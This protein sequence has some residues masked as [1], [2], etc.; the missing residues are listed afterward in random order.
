ML[1]CMHS[2]AV[3][4]IGMQDASVEHIRTVVGHRMAER[5]LLYLLLVVTGDPSTGI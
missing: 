4:A 1:V 5:Q 3:K 2:A